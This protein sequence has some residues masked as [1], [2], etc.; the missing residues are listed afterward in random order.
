MHSDT[1]LERQKRSSVSP[2]L[3][4]G[5]PCSTSS[6]YSWLLTCWPI[7]SYGL[8]DAVAQSHQFALLESSPSAVHREGWIHLASHSSLQMPLAHMRLGFWGAGQW[9]F[10]W[11]FCSLL[12]SIFQLFSHLWGSKS[13][14]KPLFPIIF[15]VTVHPWLNPDWYNLHAVSMEWQQLSPCKQLS[16]NTEEQWGFQVSSIGR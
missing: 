16:L 15:I 10:L 7:L 11:Y 9:L 3:L 5:L 14:N 1:V 8:R 13:H 12:P 4:L 6:S 2:A